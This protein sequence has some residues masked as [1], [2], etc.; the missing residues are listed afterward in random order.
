MNGIRL[1]HS[2][3]PKYSF[4]I[5]IYLN[6]SY[7]DDSPATFDRHICDAQQN[8]NPGTSYPDW[9]SPT[10]NYHKN[11]TTR[12]LFSTC[13][14]IN[15]WFT[16]SGSHTLKRAVHY[17]CPISWKTHLPFITHFL[18]FL[19]FSLF[20]SKTP[21]FWSK[22]VKFSYLYFY[23]PLNLR[24]MGWNS[25]FASK[26]QELGGG[27]IE[28]ISYHKRM[29]LLNRFTTMRFA[30]SLLHHFIRRFFV[31]NLVR[32]GAN[33]FRGVFFNMQMN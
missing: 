16:K 8:H 3:F 32:H 26:N 10:W 15:R 22:I 4:S 24:K 21:I 28:T 1:Q 20:W 30:N 19:N 12:R 27:L 2:R 29:I 9:L 23:L 33:V 14:T 6:T 18:K 7:Q 13:S 11:H 17:N 5:T 25:I 31:D